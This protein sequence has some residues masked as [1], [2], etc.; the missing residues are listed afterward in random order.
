MIG[1]LFNVDVCVRITDSH[2]ASVVYAWHDID[3]ILSLVWYLLFYVWC[4]FWSH[5][6]L[7]ALNCSVM[8]WFALLYVINKGAV[9]CWK[10]IYFS[11]WIL[12]S[13]A[14]RQM[15]MFELDQMCRMQLCWGHWSVVKLGGQCQSG[16]AVKLF[17]MRQQISFA[18]HFWHVF[19]P[20][21]CETCRVI[22]KQFWIIK[23]WQNVLWPLIH[24]LVGHDPQP[25]PWSMPLAEVEYYKQQNHFYVSFCFTVT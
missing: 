12:C 2:D 6:R 16:Q 11:S 8:C 17:Q 14:R 4:W 24:I 21:W 18:F 9:L 13:I 20:S 19:H 25:H 7:R 23:M 15:Y 22:Q 10:W 3:I 1:C 5:S